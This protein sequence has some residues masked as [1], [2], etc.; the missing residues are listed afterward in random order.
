MARRH[1][2]GIGLADQDFSATDARRT[3]FLKTGGDMTRH[4]GSKP[5]KGESP[6]CGRPWPSR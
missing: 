2:R 4:H 1:A 3:Q 5:V 6:F